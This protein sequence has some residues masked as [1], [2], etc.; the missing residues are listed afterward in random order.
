MLK[1]HTQKQLHTLTKTGA[2]A[3]ITAFSQAFDLIA[4]HTG[5]GNKTLILFYKER[6]SSR[7]HK[8]VTLM[9]NPKDLNNWMRHAK[10]VGLS[11]EKSARVKKN[12]VLFAPLTQT[13]CIQAV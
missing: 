9:D 12:K 8:L 6:I 13:V 3:I 11:L 10:K 2:N 7:F 1:E 4:G 5:L